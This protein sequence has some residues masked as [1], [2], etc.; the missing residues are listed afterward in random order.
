MLYMLCSPAG[1]IMA[2]SSIK[3][4]ARNQISIPKEARRQLKI[5]AGDRLLLDLQAGLIILFPLHGTFTQSLAGLNC[6]IWEDSEEYV[7]H[8]RSEWIDATRY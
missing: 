3:V 8:E 1:V 2:I 4:T 5:K 7:L 6:K